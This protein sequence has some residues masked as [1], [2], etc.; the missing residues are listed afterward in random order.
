[1]VD[2]DI[3]CSRADVCRMTLPHS[4]RSGARLE[5]ELAGVAKCTVG[6]DGNALN[7]EYGVRVA[8][9]SRGAVRNTS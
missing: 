9:G 7:I 5:I 4:S 1:M 2:V 8:F 3:E 6:F